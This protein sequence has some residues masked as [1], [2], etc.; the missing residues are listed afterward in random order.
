MKLLNAMEKGDG[1]THAQ[2]ERFC[3]LLA[4]F[5]PHLAEE[6]WSRLRQP[7][8]RIR[9]SRS[10]SGQAPKNY[11]SVHAQ[12]WPTYDEALL[13]RATVQVPVQVNGRVRGTVTIPADASEQ[14][15]VFAAK[16]DPNVTKHLGDGSVAK[17]IYIPGRLLNFVIS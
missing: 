5:A 10:E 2:R 1:T 12:A 13:K 16:Q 11:Q 15:A 17:T 4:P 3:A 7:K 9:D 6:L 14:D 8:S